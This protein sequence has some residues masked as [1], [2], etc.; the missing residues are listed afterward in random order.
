MIFRKQL[1]NHVISNQNQGVIHQE[2]YKICIKI[3]S[4][5]GKHVGCR[6]KQLQRKF[7][8]QIYWL[9]KSGIWSWISKKKKCLTTLNWNF[10]FSSKLTKITFLINLN[11]F[12]AVAMF[13]NST[14]YTYVSYFFAGSIS[15]RKKY[16]Q[17]M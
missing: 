7:Y 17:K 13:F 6:R 9:K 14:E 16:L 10:N 8:K 5:S 11:L 1:Y 12:F 15:K 2:D 4:F 3:F